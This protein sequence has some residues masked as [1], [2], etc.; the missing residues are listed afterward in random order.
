MDY[1]LLG[2]SFAFL[3]FLIWYFAAHRESARRKTG[4]AL[5]TTLVGI[6]L[7]SLFVPNAQKPRQENDWPVNIK[8]GLD[9][10]GGNQF[11]LQLEGNPSKASLDQAVEQIRKRV[12]VGGVGEPMIQPLGENR[13]IVQIPGVSATDKISYRQKLQQ[14]AKLEFKLVHPQN[15]ELL[16]AI[17][18]GKAAIPFDY[19][20]LEFVD[21]DSKGV[22]FTE[23]ILVKK[24]ADMSGKYVSR[25]F[26]DLDQFGRP[27]VS[28]NFDSTG[29]EIFGKLTSNNVGR[30][31]AVVLDG[32]VQSAP[33][34]NE[35]ITGGNCT[36]SGGFMTAAEAENLA[37]VL[38]NPLENPVSIVD[39]RGVDPSLGAASVADGF[40][41][42]MIGS[43]VVI[44]FVI[45]YYRL[46]GVIAVFSLL[47]NMIIL[48]GLLAQFGFT[49]TLPG[50]AGIILTIGVA[51]DANVL[52]YERISEELRS[53]RPLVSAVHAGF[54]KAF[55]SIMDANVTT[56]IAALIMFW[57]GSGAIQGFAITLCLG[58]ISS[59]FAALVITRNCFDWLLLS[60]S[61]KTLNMRRVFARANFNFMKMR[62]P[63][64][65]L[66]LLLAFAGIA[67]W[68]Y[69]GDAVYGVDF[70]GG[71]LLTLKYEKR[72]P[73]DNLKEVVGPSAVTQYQDL[74]TNSENVLTVR[75]PYDQGEVAEAALMNAFPEASF[76][77]LGLDKV[78][79]VI[80]SEF[81]QQAFIA[82]LLGIV[83]IFFYIMLRFE[84]AFAVGAIVALLHD[85]IIALGLFSLNGREF[86][87]P[88]V[89]AILTVAGYSI[90]DTIVI[91]D[92]IREGLRE[93]HGQ[94]ANLPQ[95]FN[96]CLNATLSRTLLTSGTTL[97]TVT[98]LFLFGGVA[99]ND[100]ALVL[101]I[102]ILAGTYSSIFIACPVVLMMG[103]GEIVRQKKPAIA[104]ASVS[105]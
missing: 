55:S 43:A 102:G 96:A 73:D 41:A 79:A 10:S 36:I 27:T 46:A 72:I 32:V 2:A 74:I 69:R 75:T 33:N 39:E 37:S 11:I 18:A 92:R 62:K 90:N 95:L 1:Y 66:S 65:A 34:I 4:L 53:G 98:A 78:Q 88:V 86:S 59:V 103:K 54:N 7:W 40:R 70:S 24:R 42:A 101:L 22:E 99:I 25:A 23:K 68:F 8:P 89:G 51:V 71:D 49:L 85:V 67:S 94:K 76:S 21:H 93:G 81:K 44:I 14:V 30:K 57:Q 38:E 58:T 97:I 83:G 52:I 82:I 19:E 47:L 105:Q 64:I 56:L 77:R 80:G 16:A 60:K 17:E 15:R 87:L 31:M 61:I 100:F 9:L 84:T 63:A 91:F 6:C 5:I 28:I 48:L 45:F 104:E 3:V 29:R 50:V 20:A 26:R 13:I 35:A 12:D